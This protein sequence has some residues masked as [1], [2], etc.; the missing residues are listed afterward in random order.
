MGRWVRNENPAL[1]LTARARGGWVGDTGRKKGDAGTGWGGRCLDVYIAGW[2][3]DG[4]GVSMGAVT[5]ILVILRLPLAVLA[6]RL[7]L[8]NLAAGNACSLVKYC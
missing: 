5:I 3:L 6:R 2:G 8:L 7:L 1:D 4:V